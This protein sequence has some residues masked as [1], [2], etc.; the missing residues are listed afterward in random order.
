MSLPRTDFTA[1]SASHI[2]TRPDSVSRLPI[3]H[4]TTYLLIQKTISLLPN[5]EAALPKAWILVSLISSLTASTGP[6]S[7]HS[8]ILETC[9]EF[10]DCHGLISLVACRDWN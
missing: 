1:S 6:A 9:R 10:I 3:S 5:A 4:L 8:S 2:L 7:V